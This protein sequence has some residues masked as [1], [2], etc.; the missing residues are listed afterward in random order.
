MTPDAPLAVVR[1]GTTEADASARWLD[2][3]V[4][5]RTLGASAGSCAWPAR[6][7]VARLEVEGAPAASDGTALYAALE[8]PAPASATLDDVT[9][10]AYRRLLAGVERAGYPHLLRVW[11]FVPRINADDDGTERYKRFC[12]GRAAAFEAHYGDGFVNR[13]PAATAVG[14]PGDTLV[15]HVLAADRP[16]RH[17][18][19]PRQM[20]PWLY[21][22]CYGPS[23]PSFARATVTP[24]SWDG[25][26]LVAGTSSIVGHRSVGAG[27]PAAQTDETLRNLEA[28]LDACG[29]PGSGGALG[30]RLSS[31]RIYVRHPGQ[32]ESIRGVLS[33][34]GCDDVAAV[35]LHAEICRAELLVEIEAIAL[36][37]S[38]QRSS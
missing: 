14:C 18:E 16:G 35:W 25:A 38:R 22:R 29:V 15:V 21:P 30:R 23:S 6:G 1:F 11:N 34:A 13:L 36:P 12:A 32:R 31:L 24:A 4:P 5:S 2:V 26:V 19:N 20:S 17:V 33:R 10:G 27:D 28:V 37:G 7:P 8:V 3:A 9:R